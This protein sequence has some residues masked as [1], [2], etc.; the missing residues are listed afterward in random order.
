MESKKIG[1]GAKACRHQSAAR[2][3]SVSIVLFP[4]LIVQTGMTSDIVYECLVDGQVRMG[5]VRSG[6]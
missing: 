5:L 4:G 2:V 1:L 6:D 3:G